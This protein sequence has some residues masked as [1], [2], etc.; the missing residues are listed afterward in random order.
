MIWTWSV[1]AGCDGCSAGCTRPRRWGQ[2]LREFHMS[3]TNL[4]VLPVKPDIGGCGVGVEHFGSVGAD[5][6]EGDRWA[7]LSRR[8]SGQRRFRL[9]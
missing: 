9:R 6:G 5:D 1:P 3:D 2:F 8:P 4:T 7:R